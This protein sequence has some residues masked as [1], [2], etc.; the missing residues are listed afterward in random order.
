MHQSGKIV[1]YCSAALSAAAIASFVTL[2]VISPWIGLSS[3]AARR[4]APEAA[5]EQAKTP[6]GDA[7]T[8]TEEVRALA[9]TVSG[10]DPQRATQDPAPAASPPLVEAAA[11]PQAGEAEA[12]PPQWSTAEVDAALM[13]CVNLLAPVTAQVIPLA[14]IRYNDCGTPAPVL[15]RSIGG[16][17]KVAVDPPMLMNCPM[18]VALNRWMEKTVQPAALATLGSP[19][20]RIAGSGYA[21][22][23]LYNLPNERRSQ[24]A[25]ADA[26]D[27]PVFFLADGRRIDLATGW[28]PTRRDLVAGV[29]LI[30]IAAKSASADGEA[31]QGAP[32]AKIAATP[33]SATAAMQVSVKSAALVQDAAPPEDKAPAPDPLSLPQAKFLRLV[34]QGACGVFTTVLGPEANDIHRTHLHLDLQDRHALNVCK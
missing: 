12:P 26:I 16:K 2:S 8:P 11:T 18:V 24:H 9:A 1:A 21:C 28:G 19:V 10:H 20:T 14:P 34:H 22:R 4:D 23:N 15:L 31:D 32:S 7:A 30:P 33:A 17:D 5:S 3:N 13:E 29:K 25:F 6:S 27:L